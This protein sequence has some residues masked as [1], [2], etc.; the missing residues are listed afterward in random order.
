MVFKEIGDER[1]RIIARK[2]EHHESKKLLRK[3]ASYCEIRRKQE[4]V[5]IMF[6]KKQ[7]SNF[8]SQYFAIFVV[9]VSIICIICYHFLPFN[10]VV[11][12]LILLSVF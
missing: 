1:I 8:N 12:G 5:A 6:Y 4:V 7:K 10:S 3:N 2:L 11:I 9:L